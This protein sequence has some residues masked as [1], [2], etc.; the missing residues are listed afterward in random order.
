MEELNFKKELS[1][2][3]RYENRGVFDTTCQYIIFLLDKIEK[4]FNISYLLIK[5]INLEY[6]KVN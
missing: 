1:K 2:V 4:D 3:M 5:K 6:D